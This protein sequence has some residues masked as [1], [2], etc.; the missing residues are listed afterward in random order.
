MKNENKKEY[1]SDE[2]WVKNVEFEQVPLRKHKPDKRL[3]QK[4]YR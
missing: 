4:L 2:E 1:P 3:Y